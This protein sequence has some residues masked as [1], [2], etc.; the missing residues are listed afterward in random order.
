MSFVCV[1]RSHLHPTKSS[2]WNED[3]HDPTRSNSWLCSSFFPFIVDRSASKTSLKRVWKYDCKQN[4]SYFIC[5]FMKQWAEF[6]DL[7]EEKI[8]GAKYR[9][10]PVV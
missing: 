8:G 3:Q 7:F 6:V 9:V 1:W 4:M 2:P 10:Q 5:C